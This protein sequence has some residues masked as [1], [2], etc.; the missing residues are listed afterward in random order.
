MPTSG[1]LDSMYVAH[2]ALYAFGPIDSTVIAYNLPESL[3]QQLCSYLGLVLLREI[4][5][6]CIVDDASREELHAL[7]QAAAQRASG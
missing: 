6:A 1:F 7:L 3:L 2:N 5:E 4:G